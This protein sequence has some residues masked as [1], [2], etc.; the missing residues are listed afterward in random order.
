[1]RKLRQ[2]GEVSYSVIAHLP[3]HFT[4]LT[5]TLGM[6]KS[7]KIRA[8]EQFDSMPADFQEDWADFRGR[9]MDRS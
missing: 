8:R 5:E 3:L 4:G 2:Y 6:A 7:W 9:V 1:M